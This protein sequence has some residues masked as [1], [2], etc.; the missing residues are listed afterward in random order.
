LAIWALLFGIAKVTNIQIVWM[1]PVMGL[2][3]LVL[4]IVCLIRA[5]R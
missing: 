5:L 3:A 1:D 2:A 4:G